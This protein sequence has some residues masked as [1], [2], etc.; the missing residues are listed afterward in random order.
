VFTPPW[1]ASKG[2]GTGPGEQQRHGSSQHQ[3]PR[4]RA[5]DIAYG[6]Q[7]DSHDP[8]FEPVLK[9]TEHVEAKTHEEDEDV[10][11]KM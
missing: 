3:R 5:G 1:Q 8:Q 4:Q 10:L 11:F 2:L 6:E 9:L 7:E